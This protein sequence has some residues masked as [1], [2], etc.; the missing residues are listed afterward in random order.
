MEDI[1][2]STMATV[3]RQMLIS[4]VRPIFDSMKKSKEGQKTI[5]ATLAASAKLIKCSQRYLSVGLGINRKRIHRAI[6]AGVARK[7]RKDRIPAETKTKISLFYKREDI[8]RVLP[9]KRFA[10]KKHGPA[11]VMQCSIK[12]AYKL[13][14]RENPTVKV[15][16]TRFTLLRPPNVRRLS[17]AFH[18]VCMCPYCMNVKCKVMAFN[19]ATTVAGVSCKK[20]DD[21]RA[22]YDALLCPKPEGSRFHRAECVDGTCEICKNYRETIRGVYQELIYYNVQCTWNHW[23]RKEGPDG[24]IRRSLQTKLSSVEQAFVELV[25]DVESPV[26]GTSF[27]QHIFTADWQFI[28]S[29]T[30]SRGTSQERTCLWSW[31]SRKIDQRCFKMKSSLRISA[32]AR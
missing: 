8:S 30:Q 1:G 15:G 6:K 3:K 12:A 21:E 22:L 20:L 31:T 24:K 29:T 5:S 18:N 27:V 32:R 14:R 4:D 23:E 25:A 10:T 13:F 17:G 2:V 7:I 16:F 28:T 19:R 11:F 26:K 9:N